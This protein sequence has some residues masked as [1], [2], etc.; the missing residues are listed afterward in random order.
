MYTSMA[1]PMKLYDQELDMDRF[2]FVKGSFHFI[3]EMEMYF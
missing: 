3:V 2:D 1:I